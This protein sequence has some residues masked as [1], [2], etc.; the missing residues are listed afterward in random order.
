M[1]GILAIGSIS[2]LSACSQPQSYPE[3]PQNAQWPVSLA[4]FHQ[5]LSLALG[6]DPPTREVTFK[7]DWKDQ[8]CL[9]PNGATSVHGKLS[10]EDVH[11]IA[12]LVHTLWSQEAIASIRG[13]RGRAEVQTGRG[14]GQWRGSGLSVHFVHSEEFEPNWYL[15]AVDR[16]RT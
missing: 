4:S 6:T 5:E 13:V 10:D 15:I 11:E 9:R 12:R 7:Y 2:L 8:S 16:W 3:V 1:R 14:C